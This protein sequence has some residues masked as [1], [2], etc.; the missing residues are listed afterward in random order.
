MFHVFYINPV[1][2]EIIT[3]KLKEKQNAINEGE[4]ILL[5][6]S[7]T[8]FKEEEK[9]NK[10]TVFSDIGLLQLLC[11]TP[12][13]YTMYVKKDDL[14]VLEKFFY[15]HEDELWVGLSYDTMEEDF[16]VLKTAMLLDN[17]INEIGDETICT[18]FNVGPGDIYNV[19]ESMKWLLYSASRI[20]YMMAPDLRVR[21]REVEL[22]MKHGIK[23][24]LLPLVKLRNI[25]RVRARRLFNNGFSSPEKIKN[26]DF[27]KLSAILGKKLQRMF[28]NRLKER[29]MIILDLTIPKKKTD[30]DLV[31]IKIS[32]LK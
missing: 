21:V 12:D 32:D 7:K 5:D 16:A 9:E 23:R 22:R 24:E 3:E 28:W 11:T 26:A 29:S 2:A 6:S 25:G 1:T 14:P 31:R 15:E 20:S 19:V 18:R 13:M 30:P 27:S 10:E 8:G 17:W 4:K